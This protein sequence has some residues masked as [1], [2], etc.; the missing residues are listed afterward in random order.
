MVNDE[1]SLRDA[2]SVLELQLW[3]SRAAVCRARRWNDARA[4]RP[5]D[6]RPDDQVETGL[7]RARSRRVTRWSLLWVGLRKACMRPRRN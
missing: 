3:E 1:F 6:F 4:G 7:A 5:H 2:L